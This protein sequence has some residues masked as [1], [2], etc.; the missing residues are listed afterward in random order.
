[1]PQCAPL[2][3]CFALN[4]LGVSTSNPHLSGPTQVPASV[5]SNRRRFATNTIASFR[6]R[7]V[8]GMLVEG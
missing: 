3:L 2:S 7:V 6:F 8:H 1:M 5:L 4:Y